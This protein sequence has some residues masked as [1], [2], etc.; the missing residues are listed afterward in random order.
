MAETTTEDFGE[1][2]PWLTFRANGNWWK[3]VGLCFIITTITITITTNGG[4]L[5]RNFRNLIL[6]KPNWITD[7]IYTCIRLLFA[8][9]LTL[10]MSH[11]CTYCS[12]TKDIQPVLMW[13]VVKQK[14]QSKC[15]SLQMD[16]VQSKILFRDRTEAMLDRTDPGPGPGHG[17]VLK[18]TTTRMYWSDWCYHKTAWNPH[19]V[20]NAWGHAASS[21]RHSCTSTE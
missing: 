13:S 4:G 18:L 2:W 9:F 1:T 6:V 7:S 3:Q 17:P 19:R 15:Y 20:I 14:Q 5:F 12:T 16:Q 21:S 11:T 8:N 10:K